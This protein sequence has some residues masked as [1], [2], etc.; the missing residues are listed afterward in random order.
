MKDTEELPLVGGPGRRPGANPSLWIL[1]MVLLAG[2]FGVSYWAFVLTATGQQADDNALRGAIDYLSGDNTRRTALS[3]LE[4]MPLASGVICALA[5]LVAALVRRDA[6][7]P[8]VAAVSFGAAAGSTQLLKH[9]FLERP[10]KNISEATMNSFPSGHTTVAAAAMVAVFLVVS[11]RWR[12]LVAAAGGLYAA[13]TGISTFVLGWHR[14]SDIV[15]AYLIAAFWGVL[16]GL[17]ILRRRPAWNTWR[18]PGDHWAS[19]GLWQAVLW[20][21]GIIGALGTVGTYLFAVQVLGGAS[22]ASLGWYLVCGVLFIIGATGCVF[23]LL[24]ALFSAQTRAGRR[25]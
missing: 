17:V 20:I 6:F 8:A 9:V 22:S 12:P 7:A 24:G 15:A 5:L 10:D 18:G 3:F 19:A 14:P 21:P 11:P 23:G 4:K 16:S 2:V 13:V 25:R 1:C